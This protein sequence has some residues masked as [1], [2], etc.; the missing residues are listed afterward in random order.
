M[1]I[2]GLEGIGGEEGER[3]GDGREVCEFGEERDEGF[4]PGEECIDGSFYP[5]DDNY[6]P[7]QKKE[8]CQWGKTPH[9]EREGD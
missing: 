6:I 2:D 8:V 4:A 1:A 5:Y 7:V 9:G 3:E